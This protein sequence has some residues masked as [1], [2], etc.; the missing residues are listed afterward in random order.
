[1]DRI[2]CGRYVRLGLIAGLV[3]WFIFIA[4]LAYASMF[5]PDVPAQGGQSLQQDEKAYTLRFDMP[6]ISREQLK[7]SIEDAVVR[8]DTPGEADYYRHGGILQYVLRSLL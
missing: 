5:V 7:V 8:I 2:E 1:M 3:A 4:T 6:G